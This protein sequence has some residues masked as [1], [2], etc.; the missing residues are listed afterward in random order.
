MKIKSLVLLLS[1]SSSLLAM[2]DAE[3]NVKNL[4]GDLTYVTLIDAANKSHSIN[5]FVKA[6]QL[7]GMVENPAGLPRLKTQFR[8][9]RS[10]CLETPN[11]TIADIENALKK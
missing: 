6:F 7:A 10:L 4:V 11:F 8:N 9:V 2:E 3:L 1:L 5:Q